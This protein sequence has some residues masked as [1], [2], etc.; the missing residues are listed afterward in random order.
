M[1]II[2]ALQNNSRVKPGINVFDSTGAELVCFLNYNKATN[3][4]M[5]RI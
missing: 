2:S 1:P 4:F 3:T 5:V